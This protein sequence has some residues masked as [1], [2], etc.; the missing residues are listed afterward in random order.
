MSLPTFVTSRLL[1]TRLTRVDLPELC[2]VLNDIF[3]P[4]GYAFDIIDHIRGNRLVLA[5]DMVQVHILLEP[6]TLDHDPL[7]ALAD[8][9]FH[10][11]ER[12]D[13]PGLITSHQC[14]AEITVQMTGSA[15]APDRALFEVMLSLCQM[16]TT[17]LAAMMPP[18]MIHWIQS[19]QLFLPSKF[20]LMDD[21]LF[22]LPLFIKPRLFSS[23]RMQEDM[24]VLGMWAEGAELFLDRPLVFEEAPVTLQWLQQRVFAFVEHYR[25]AESLPADGD[26]FGIEPEE[27][28]RVQTKGRGPIAL[29]LR[30][31]GG[32]LMLQPDPKIPRADGMEVARKSGTPLER[33]H[34]DSPQTA[35]PLPL[36]AASEL[37]GE[38]KLRLASEHRLAAARSASRDAQFRHNTVAMLL[39]ARGPLDVQL[40]HRGK[41]T[42]ILTGL[43]LFLMPLIGLPLA[44]WNW[45]RGPHYYATSY[46]TAGAVIALA[47]FTPVLRYSPAGALILVTGL[48]AHPAFAALNAPADTTF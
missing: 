47:I 12:I 35:T 9:P 21:M 26:T 39:G 36:S 23:G 5:H 46:A 40:R 1:Y 24:Q 11:T 4:A 32:V 29:T 19:E 18:I 7:L 38:D 31:R 14:H 13:W 3:S 33:R 10:Q 44:I 34:A 41:V 45:M 6:E 48:D 8:E 16:T 17:A 27:I 15:K 43:S 2:A 30:E 22:P 42:W 37:S 20:Q 25:H 28:I